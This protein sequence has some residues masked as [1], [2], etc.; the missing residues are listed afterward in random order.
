[1]E[2]NVRTTRFRD[3]YRRR[4]WSKIEGKGGVLLMT[5]SK[6]YFVRTPVHD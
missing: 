1:M 2:I 6:G 3:Y 4:V 5:V